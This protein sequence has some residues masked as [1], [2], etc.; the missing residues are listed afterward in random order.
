MNEMF[1]KWRFFSVSP[2][3]GSLQPTLFA[4][5]D[6]TTEQLYNYMIMLDFFCIG[7]TELFGTVREGNIQ[8]EKTNPVGLEPTPGTLW[9]VNQ[10]FRPLGHTDIKLSIYCLTVSWFMNTNGHMI[11][12]VCIGYGLIANT[13]LFKQLLY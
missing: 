10:R 13:K 2:I 5:N 11:K 7:S 9:Q 8:N 1:L 3:L 6:G 4:R 12:L